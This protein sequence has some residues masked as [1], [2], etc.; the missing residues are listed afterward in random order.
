MNNEFESPIITENGFQSLVH[1]N[2][3]ILQDGN[4]VYPNIVPNE[5]AM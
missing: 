2:F 3:P 4:N 1:L 5:N